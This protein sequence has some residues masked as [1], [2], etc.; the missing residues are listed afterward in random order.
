MGEET[1]Y[2]RGQSH[3]AAHKEINSL[4]SHNWKESIHAEGV[5]NDHARDAH[6][7]RTPIVALSVQLEGLDR[8]VIVAAHSKNRSISEC[9]G[10]SNVQREELN[11]GA[12]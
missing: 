7:R 1:R 5:V 11:R 9:K 12:P 10:P 6:H 2:K 3:E 4:V 8:R